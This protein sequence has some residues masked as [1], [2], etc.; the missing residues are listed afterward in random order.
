MA[1]MTSGETQQLLREWPFFLSFSPAYKTYTRTP[2]E[3]V[4]GRIYAFFKF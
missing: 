3:G 2:G 4:Q 1:A